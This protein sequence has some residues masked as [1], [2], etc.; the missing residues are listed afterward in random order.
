MIEYAHEVLSLVNV[1]NVVTVVASSM[2]IPHGHAIMLFVYRVVA[3]FF[4]N[5][6]VRH[7]MS[8]G[9]TRPMPASEHG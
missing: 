5:L 9:R 8:T 4:G 2:R 7:V 6:I 1:V 3:R